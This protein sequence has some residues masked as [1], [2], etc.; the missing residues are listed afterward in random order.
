MLVDLR[1]DTV[2]RPTPAM[3]RAMAEAEV[4]DDQ[5]GED[6]TVNRLQEMFADM[7]GKQ[8]AIFVPS[9]TMGNQVA[10]R[11]L[12][13]PGDAVV[14]GARQHIVVYEAGAG[15]LNAGVTWLSLPDGDGTFDPDSVEHA[16][17][18]A[19]HHQ[20]VVAAVAIEDTHMAAGGTVWDTSRLKALGAVTE[21]RRVAVHLDGARLWHAAIASCETLRTRAEIATTVTCCLSKG[22]GAPV[23]SLLA[24]PSDLIGAARLHRQR[25]GGAMRQSGVLAAAGL[26][27]IRDGFE[28]LAEDHVRARRLAEAV[29]ERWPRCGLDPKGVQTNIVAFSPP[30]PEGLLRHLGAAGVLAGTVAP[31]VVRLVTH[32]DVDD[33]GIDAACS[34]LSSA[35]GP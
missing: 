8:D 31:G 35:P 33:A 19:A 14:A 29:A 20:P 6:P 17:A 28:R 7:T 9:G 1:S 2:T 25:L 5:Y 27:A 3:R 21:R 34:A 12:T 24:G 26:V 13:R 18:S 30:D 23:G 15:P 4:G 22:L 10:L 16:I 11:A 32:A